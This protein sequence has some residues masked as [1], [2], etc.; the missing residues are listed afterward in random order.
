MVLLGDINEQHYP[1]VSFPV[2]PFNMFLGDIINNNESYVFPLS[3]DSLQSFDSFEEH[4]QQQQ[5]IRFTPPRTSKP[6]TRKRIHPSQ[7]QCTIC[8]KMFTRPYNLRS[9][10]KTHTKERPFKCVHPD[11]G[12]TFARPH[13]LKRHELLHSGIKPYVCSCGKNFSRN[14]AFKRHKQVNRA[15]FVISAAAPRKRGR[16]S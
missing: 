10:Q 3:P 15:C 6:H 1:P 12:W 2:N 8:F 14:D 13:D 4:V 5:E 9:H 16:R 7:L 11:C